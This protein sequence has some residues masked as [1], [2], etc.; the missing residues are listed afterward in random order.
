MACHWIRGK[1][2]SELIWVVGDLRCFN[3]HGATPTNTTA[4]NVLRAQDENDWRTDEDIRLLAVLAALFHDLGKANLAFQKKLTNCKPIANAYRHEWVSLRLFESFVGQ[5]S[6]QS[7]LARLTAGPEQTDGIWVK[8]LLRDGLDRRIQSPF[9]YLPVLARVVGWMIVSHHRLP[10]QEKG[11]TLH[12]AVL[13]RL[14][15]SIEDQWCSSRTDIDTK[16]IETCWAFQ[17]GLPFDSL[18]WRR[19]VGKIARAILLR[20]DMLTTD[21][22]DNPYILHL[23]RMA[24]ML[25]DHHY[26]SEPSHLRYGDISHPLYANTDRD[27]GALKQRLDEHLIGVAVNASRIVRVLPRL[28]LKLPR[29]AR[30]KGFRQR[31]KDT[32]FR[33]QDRA[34]DLADTIQ[35][36]TEQQGFFGVNMASTGY[37]KTLANGRIIYALASP[38][39][40]ARFSIAVGLRTL[41]L[42]TGDVYREQMGLGAED[43]AVLVGGSAIRTLHEYQS[44][45]DTKSASD[46]ESMAGL[47]PE[48]HYVHFEGSLEDGVLNRW[49]GK[50][51]DAKKL[52]NAPVLVCTIDH[53]MPAT[54][55]T[56]GGHQIAPML[57]LLSADLVLDEPDDFGIEDLPA[58]TRLVHW[59]GLLGSRVLLSSATLP[60]ALV[61]GLFQAYL[62]GRRIYQCNRGIPGQPLNVWCAWF[63]EFSA[64]ASEHAVVDSFQNV[65]QHFVNKRL[66]NLTR[67]EVRRRAEIMLLPIT[68]GQKRETICAELAVIVHQQMC[69]LHGQHHSN[70]PVTGKRVSFGLIRM[71]NIGPLVETVSA[72][73]ALGAPE[74]YRIHLCVYHSQHP[75]LVRSGIE[76]RLDR[77]LNRKNPEEVFQAPDIR[78]QLDT[79]SEQDHIFVVLATPVAEV[80]RDHDYDWG[81]VEPSSMR[82][83]IQLAGRIRRHRSG[84]CK[85]PNLY[86]LDTNVRHLE[87]KAGLIAFCRPGFESEQFP[88]DLHQLSELLTSEQV[89]VIDASNRISERAEPYPRKNLVDLE[90]ARLR[91]LMIGTDKGEQLK[92]MPV[93]WWWTTHAGL[94]GELQRKQPFRYD[95]LGR[96]RYG[97]FPDED[98]IPKFMRFEDNG[99][100]TPVNNLLH[101][102]SLEPGPRISFWGET[103]Y[104]EALETLADTLQMETDVCARRFGILDLPEKGADQGW[105]YHPV[106]GFSLYR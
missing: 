76:Q 19:E 35:V 22:F 46:S 26:S 24:L 27:T 53:L 79:T 44:E 105:N 65:H 90:H 64:E 54:E 103:D 15:E 8:N 73:C 83:I 68:S 87:Q 81:I 6:D 95:P 77:I 36:R 39:R 70:D 59:A 32:R 56:R 100:L 92:T 9:K 71:A 55:S 78:Q 67:T 50:N 99:T 106:L 34:F 48:H 51:P 88:L 41:T 66:G 11:A 72:L 30:H 2:H 45:R 58:L 29:I 63:D 25:A 101:Q 49:L 21:W 14:P 94:S 104:F 38:Q 57:R 18:P 74:N 3:A 42:Q 85:I 43:M 28:A 20:H 84:P 16:G 91:A 5:D 89:A 82:S 102:V 86:L 97:L 7:W 13:T 61:Q 52:I 10:V 1:D 17:K 31:S 33:W 60:P 69:D 96:Q 4:S 75:L 93:N 37:G 62:E 40:G 98:G 80:G 47:L 12:S 23:S